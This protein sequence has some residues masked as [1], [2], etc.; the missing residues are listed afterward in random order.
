MTGRAPMRNRVLALVLLS[1]I[2]GGMTY[3]LWRLYGSLRRERALGVGN[4]FPVITV[5]PLTSDDETV[6][7][8]AGK[9]TLIVFFR[10][11]CPH[12]VSELLR[13]D[14]ACRQISPTKLACIALAFDRE[15]ETRAWWL[16]SGLQMEGAFVR[17]SEFI[18]RSLD[19]LTAVPLVFLVDE[20]G[21]ITYKRAG[22]RSEDYDMQL[23]RNF[24]GE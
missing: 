8:P 18:R 14:R 20:K 21:I 13:L 24:V 1:I 11:D 6:H 23:L 3:G 16:Q 15:R 7:L 9:K 2:A 12:C 5:E 22:E 4:P 17:D 10:W 19:W